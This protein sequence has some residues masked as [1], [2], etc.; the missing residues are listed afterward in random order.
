M[1]RKEEE[2]GEKSLNGQRK[3]KEGRGGLITCAHTHTQKIHSSCFDL[4]GVERGGARK[5]ITRGSDADPSSSSSPNMCVSYV[6]R[7][8]VMLH[9]LPPSPAGH[10]HGDGRREGGG[11]EEEKDWKR[12][13]GER[14][15]RERE[16]E[17]AT[18]GKLLF[19]QREKRRGGGGEEVSREP[20]KR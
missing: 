18:G 8:D 9:L 13:R 17:S 6:T 10:L 12:R 5:G 19:R 4:K 14:G 20:P 2:E 3:R 1:R 16:R 7:V 15:E 11:E